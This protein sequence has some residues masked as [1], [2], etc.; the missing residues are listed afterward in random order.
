MSDYIVPAIYVRNTK[1]AKY[2]DYIVGKLKPVETRTRD[3]L[4][5]FVGQRV[6]VIRTEAGKKPMIIGSAFVKEKAFRTAEQL[7]Y[8]RDLTM[9]PKGSEFDA[10]QGGKWCYYLNDAVEYE[11]FPLE[12]LEV[13]KRTRS[14]AML[15]SPFPVESFD[16]VNMGNKKRKLTS[17]TFEH[18]GGNT[19]VYSARLGTDYICGTLEEGMMCYKKD[20][21]ECYD[22]GNDG[23]VPEDSITWRDIIVSIIESC[24]DDAI[25]AMC[26][27]R[28]DCCAWHECND[29]DSTDCSKLGESAFCRSNG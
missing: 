20:P 9:I 25:H 10:S 1:E 11:P 19:W 23:F 29:D 17:V 5:H 3:V 21:F 2:A 6:L 12:R 8:I 14:F 24:N 28:Q 7:D 15:R 18:T 26:D 27:I 13:E 4:G 16:I 22:G